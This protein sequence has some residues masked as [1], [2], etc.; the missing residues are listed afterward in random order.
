MQIIASRQ[1]FSEFFKNKKIAALVFNK[2]CRNLLRFIKEGLKITPFE[3]QYVIDLTLDYKRPRVKAMAL[4]L[5]SEDRLITDYRKMQTILD[6]KKFDILL[7]F[8]RRFGSS[9]LDKPVNDFAHCSEL[10]AKDYDDYLQ[11]EGGETAE[12]NF[13]WRMDVIDFINWQAD[14]VGIYVIS[15]F[16]EDL[17]P[18][19]N[20]NIKKDKVPCT[21]DFVSVR[22]LD[23]VQPLYNLNKELQDAK[24]R[25]IL[26]TDWG[27]GKTSFLLNQMKEPNRDF[28]I[29]EDSWFALVSEYFVPI[30]LSAYSV[31]GY[32]ANE[33]SQAWSKDPNKD[34]CVKLG[35]RLEEYVY[36]IPSDQ[37]L[38]L[39]NLP[40]YFKNSKF[41]IV[42]KPDQTENDIKDILD[43]FKRYYNLTDDKISL[44]NMDY[45]GFEINP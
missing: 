33:I 35:G 9:Y 21:T 40:G 34:I 23:L 4:E 19:E 6:N 13:R 26:G 1:E 30:A 2:D 3:I 8:E 28:G 12:F 45:D 15:A 32:I 38:I 10:L 37:R 31:K 11:K 7:C 43:D 41:D 22:I 5:I 17:F 20:P 42:L 27:V 18:Y 14:Q 39:D 29:A 36:G 16:W 44:H 24:V 25:F